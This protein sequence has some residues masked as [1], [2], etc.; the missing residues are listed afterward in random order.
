MLRCNKFLR[1]VAFDKLTDEERKL[2]GVTLL[3]GVFSNSNIATLPFISQHRDA[4]LTG[5]NGVITARNNLHR[6]NAGLWGSKAGD[7]KD[8][9]PHNDIVTLSNFVN[10]KRFRD[11]YNKVRTNWLADPNGSYKKRIAQQLDQIMGM[12]DALGYAA[13]NKDAFNKFNSFRGMGIWDYLFDSADNN[14]KLL[15]MANGPMGRFMSPEQAERIRNNYGLLKGIWRFKKFFS[16]FG[17]W[18]PVDD[19]EVAARGQQPV[20][21]TK[22]AKPYWSSPSANNST[23]GGKTVIKSDRNIPKVKKT[24]DGKTVLTDDYKNKIFQDGLNQ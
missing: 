24:R 12:G 20:D 19:P 17:N 14:Y 16:E 22:L 23:Q 7:A 8:Y 6:Y 5:I 9:D 21:Y 1:K 3:P 13:N 10:N 2:V 4:A 15:Q 11:N 18:K